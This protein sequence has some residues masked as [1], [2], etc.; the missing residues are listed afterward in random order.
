ME[1]CTMQMKVGIIGSGI[2]ALAS[3]I[4]LRKLGLSVTVF[5]ANDTIGGKIVEQR[6]GDFR[7]DMGP[8]VFT[9]PHLVQDLLQTLDP[10]QSFPYHQLHES[11]RYFFDDGQQ[12][13]IPTHKEKVAKTLYAAFGENEAK[14]LRYLTKMEAN[15]KAI[16]PVFIQISLHRFKHLFAKPII[17]ALSRLFKYGLHQT[18]HLQNRQAFANSKTIQIFDRLATY[19]GSSPCL[20][21]TSPSPR[22]GLLSRMPS[23]A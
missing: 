12:V 14:A 13:N 9:E 8:S 23:S 22:D 19:N 18:M 21:Y 11:C 3:A 5:E 16:Y 6:L 15:Y 1:F 10:T 2:G 4:E 20:L 17:K 7:F